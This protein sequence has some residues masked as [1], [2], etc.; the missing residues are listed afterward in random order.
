MRLRLIISILVCVLIAVTLVLSVNETT[1]SD[2][3]G[4]FTSRYLTKYG[5]ASQCTTCH[6][7]IPSGNANITACRTGIDGA[8]CG[9]NTY[10]LA[11]KLKLT[12]HSGLVTTANARNAINAVDVLDLDSDGFDTGPEITRGSDPASADATLDVDITASGFPDEVVEGDPL[13]FAV[14]VKN[15][16]APANGSTFPLPDL[17]DLSATA[18]V[19]NA[20]GTFACEA[21][22]GP[23]A[24]GA[25]QSLSCTGNVTDEMIDNNK[26][27]LRA[28]AS[29]QWPSGDAIAA[30]DATVTLTADVAAFELDAQADKSQVQQGEQVVFSF[31]VR[32][33]GRVA[34]SNVAITPAIAGCAVAPVTTLAAGQSEQRTCTVQ[35][36]AS[37]SNRTVTATADTAGGRG[38]DAASDPL[39]VTVDGGDALQLKLTL[40]VGP[41]VQG[42]P[43][44]MVVDVDNS[45][46]TALDQI[47]VRFP[48]F[49]DCDEALD[50]LAPNGSH[51]YSCAVVP[52]TVGL[53]TVSGVGAALQANVA[54]TVPVAATLNVIARARIGDHHRPDCLQRW[55]STSWLHCLQCRQCYAARSRDSWHR[56]FRL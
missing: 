14:E 20:T 5:Q 21:A 18:T 34:L 23:L 36:L 51:S 7:S 29:A 47:D 38:L 11:L 31:T 50:Q 35:L 54:I 26:L 40:P 2:S 37:L 42:E 55:Y 46:L 43:V 12:P 9:L 44:P 24:A 10:G 49:P 4:V 56:T 27:T 30:A 33:P 17:S 45:G 53:L 8:E 6:T 19:V 25:T 28:V 22:P 32:N 48:A 39:N 41:A 1:R 16:A 13:V 15:S 52:P 3:G